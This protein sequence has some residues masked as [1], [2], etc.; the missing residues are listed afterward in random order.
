MP[1]PLPL[2]LFSS[3]LQK[4]PG[5]EAI[6]TSEQNAIF[7]CHVLLVKRT[8]AWEPGSVPPFRT[9]PLPFP[10]N[11]WIWVENSLPS[12]KNG[13]TTLSKT[14]SGS[15]FLLIILQ[16]PVVTLSSLPRETRSYMI[17]P[18]SPLILPFSPSDTTLLAQM[19]PV[20]PSL[21]ALVTP[22]TSENADCPGHCTPVSF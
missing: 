21:R 16:W 7:N 18:Y 9:P 8:L 11:Y 4:P 13:W 19:P 12:L 2:P 1:S 15:N 5:R 17:W 6:K 3:G 22:S 10:A 14:P 20:H